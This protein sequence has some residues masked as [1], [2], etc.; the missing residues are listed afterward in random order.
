MPSSGTTLLCLLRQVPLER[1][2]SDRLGIDDWAWRKGQRY[3]TLIA[4]LVSHRPVDV[5][6]DRTAETVTAWHGLVSRGQFDCVQRAR[7]LLAE[8]NKRSANRNRRAR[9]AR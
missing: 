8:E 4:D 9:A 3:G 5:L 1:L 6:A 7:P 2:K